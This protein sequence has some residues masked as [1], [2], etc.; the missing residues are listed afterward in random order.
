MLFLE[1][2]ISKLAVG[3]TRGV[4]TNPRSREVKCSTSDFR[5]GR[6]WEDGAEG[7]EL[8]K[9]PLICFPGPD[10]GSAIVD[11]ENWSRKNEMWSGCGQGPLQSNLSALE[12]V[13]PKSGMEL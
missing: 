12:G 1:L 11:R 13:S 10:P 9:A 3:G 7:R 5:A 8:A 4:S 6:S 2:L